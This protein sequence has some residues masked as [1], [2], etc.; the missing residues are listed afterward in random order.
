MADRYRPLFK[1]DAGGMAEV[2]VAEAESVAGF[3]KR[4]AIKRILPAL[5]KEE[6]FVRMFLDEARLSLRLNHANI[7]TVFDIGRSSST[8]FIVMEYIDGTNLKYL[9]QYL[10]R[11]KRPVPV[12]VAV[13]ILNEIL[14]GLDYA[15]NLR[16]ES[17]RELGI[18]HRDISPPN[19]LMS[20]NGEVKLTDFGLAKAS[21]QLES[22]DP[23]VVKGKFAYLSPEAARGQEVDRCADIFAVGILAWEM[24]TGD[25]LFLG[26][27]DFETVENIR[28]AEIPSVCAVNPDVPEELEE[29]VRKA[30]AKDLSQRYQ[31]ASDFADD[32]LG[33]LFSRKLK[34]SSRNL[35]QLLDEMRASAPED[36]LSAAAKAEKEARESDGETSNLILKLIADEFD[37][38]RSL[39]EEDSVDPNKS[40][41]VNNLLSSLD[42][43]DYDPSA[44]LRLDEFDS[45]E[46]A[47]TLGSSETTPAPAPHSAPMHLHDSTGAQPVARRLPLENLANNTN[48]DGRRTLV[49]LIVVLSVVLAG[50]LTGYLFWLS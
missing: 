33:F 40:P 28:R 12:P 47:R 7:V 18:V 3:T 2:Y 38:I 34:V 8:Y 14:K 13:W 44:P 39:D 36:T 46:D 49:T 24:L 9:L 30:L 26:S 32:L 48:N 45:H 41:R 19:I 15:H 25:R 16:D 20:W 50:G 22:T 5:L 35:Q 4:V 6:R 37:N 43:S 21:T 10:S 23:G 11:R 31:H 29:I 27:N 1:L 17:S 42:D